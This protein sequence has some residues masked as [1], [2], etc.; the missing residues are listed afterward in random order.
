MLR[1][2]YVFSALAG[3]QYFTILDARKG[4]HQVKIDP[5]DR[6]KTAFI[7]HRGLYQ[8][9]RMPF[10]LKNAPA[11]FQRL[12]DE[13]VGNLRWVAALVYIDDL[14]IYSDTWKEHLEHV[15]LILRS[16]IKIG[17]KLA[18][19]KCKFGFRD[20]KLLGHGLSRY[21]LHTLSEKVKAITELSEPKTLGALHRVCGMFGYYRGFIP[22]FSVI[23]APLNTLK[24]SQ[25]VSASSRRDGKGA[26]GKEKYN[27][28]FDISGLW[29]P[30]CQK[31][32]DELKERLIHAP[33]LAHPRFDRRFYLYTDA[34]ADG[35]AG[36]LTQRWF[37]DDYPKDENLDFLDVGL[38]SWK[39]ES[40]ESMVV[41]TVDERVDWDRHYRN[42]A[43]WRASYITCVENVDDSEDEVNQFKLHPDGTLRYKTLAGSRICLPEALIRASLQIAHDNLGHFG[44]KKTY[45]RIS[46]T[47]YRP[48]LS[49][50]VKSYIQSCPKCV[51]NK[52]KRKLP[53]GDLQ[54]I[55]SEISPK[56]FETISFDMIVALPFSKGYDAIMVVIDKFSKYGIFVSAM[57]N[58]TAESSAKSFFD[59]VVRRGWLPTKFITDRDPRFMGAFGKSLGKML[60]V[61]HRFSTAYHAQTDGATE[62]L[63]QTLE[64]ALRAYTSPMQDDWV[65]HLPM[66]ELAYNSARGVTTGFSPFELLYAQPQDIVSRLLTPNV[67]TEN[68]DSAKDFMEMAANRIKDAQEMIRL[69]VASQ[70]KYYDKRHSPMTDWKKGDLGALRL[71]LHP[72]SAVK[73]NKIGPQKLPPY[74]VLEVKSGG[75]ALRLDFPPELKIHPVVS[76]QHVDRVIPDAFN[77]PGAQPPPFVKFPEYV[78]EKRKVRGGK[79]KYKVRFE[80]YDVSRA[81]WLDEVDIPAVLVKEFEERTSARRNANS[82]VAMDLV[83]SG[84]SIGES[85]NQAVLP[86]FQP[87]F[88]R[89]P[90]VRPKPGEFV[91]RPV[92]YIS[93]VTH[94]FERNYES[95]ERE[96]ACVSWCFQRCRHLL[97][98][99]K[100]TVI[101]DHAPIREVLRSS[102]N[103]VYSIRIDKAAW[104]L[105]PYLDDLEVVYRPGKDHL[106]VDHLSRPEK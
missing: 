98:G 70:K 47:Y 60:G 56:A 27:S 106:N 92:L 101:T 25:S 20:V 18:V 53:E 26:N 28:K 58:F 97:E 29:T 49:K 68:N 104:Q 99:S 6:Y 103:T 76:A 22:R 40:A 71:D 65:E 61:D 78:F 4:Y 38:S 31:A 50:V 89:F 90:I 48:G 52:I 12:M 105:A 91:E 42:D 41:I 17:L 82:F 75:R 14:L 24:K 9:K 84:N 59:N 96:L 46:E 80:G 86:Q 32:F 102:A 3:K 51:Q 87:L 79:A 100:C 19:D 67:I 11:V 83:K 57:S 85:G 1:A 36:V 7:S 23:A 39:G 55:D 73:V 45:D 63:N 16:V 66:I 30:E 72:V 2:D 15:D 54:P 10:G 35:F 43:V 69:A 5:V 94:P 81:E 33:I 21:G 88:N 74:K 34:S 13:V 64:I 62:R 44:Y 37:F 95:T 8:F 77:R 93:R